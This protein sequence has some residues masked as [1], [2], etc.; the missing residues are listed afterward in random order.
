LICALL[1]AKSYQYVAHGTSPFTTVST[2]IG[3]TFTYT[4]TADCFSAK[5]ATTLGLNNIYYQYYT[6]TVTK[7]G[8]T[9]GT[10]TQSPAVTVKTAIHAYNGC[11]HT[12][13]ANWMAQP[14]VG[15]STTIDG[16]GVAAVA[17]GYVMSGTSV[18][19]CTAVSIVSTAILTSNVF[20]GAKYQHVNVLESPNLLT[21]AITTNTPYISVSHNE[22]NYGLYTA[23]DISVQAFIASPNG[24]I[25]GTMGFVTKSASTFYYDFLQM[26]TFTGQTQFGRGGGA[27]TSPCGWYVVYAYEAPAPRYSITATTPVS[28]ANIAPTNV[29]ATVHMWTDGA[30]TNAISAFCFATLAA[31]LN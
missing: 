16:L 9:Y 7:G 6:F 1:V 26:N 2:A 25:L 4:V 3:G 8:I 12:H 20:Y 15:S 30:L 13:L 21:A 14:A 23:K 29:D 28:T 27:S 11:Y 31:L 10:V 24:I 5:T 19:A 22:N 17:Y 18:T